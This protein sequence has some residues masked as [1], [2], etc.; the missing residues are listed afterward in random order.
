MRKGC[1]REEKIGK[2]KNVENQA[3]YDEVKTRL[4]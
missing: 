1:D 2:E 3:N 4:C